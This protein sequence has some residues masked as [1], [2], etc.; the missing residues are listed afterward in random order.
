MGYFYRMVGFRYNTLFSVPLATLKVISQRSKRRENKLTKSAA[1]LDLVSAF[2]FFP[3]LGESGREF[4]RLFS[5]F[6]LD[7]IGGMG[8][9]ASVRESG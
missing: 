3:S 2:P 9:E 8:D 1:D 6:A 5:E 4:S 7:T